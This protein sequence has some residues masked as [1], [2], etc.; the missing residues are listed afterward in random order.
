MSL[1]HIQQLMQT[2]DIVQIPNIVARAQNINKVITLVGVNVYAIDGVPPRVVDISMLHINQQGVVRWTNGLV[3][4]EIQIPGVWARQQNIDIEQL[5]Q[6]KTWTMGWAS[7]MRHLAEHHQMIFLSPLEHQWVA[8]Q[9]KADTPCVFKDVLYLK[10]LYRNQHPSKSNSLQDMCSYYQ[11]NLDLH[12]QLKTK[13]LACARIFENILR[14][15][16]ELHQ[17]EKH[18][19]TAPPTLTKDDLRRQVLAASQQTSSPKEFFARVSQWCPVT[20]QSNGKRILGYGIHFQGSFYKGSELSPHLGWTQI[21][22]ERQWHMT[23]SEQKEL[24]AL[25]AAHPA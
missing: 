13:T 2:D 14:T 7:A 17:P 3:K 23:E 12:Y 8:Q 6:A 21:Q 1:K 24:I 4:P 15:G 19:D 18:E 9:F 25:F 10:D 5:E 22:Q 20:I 11:L 16:L